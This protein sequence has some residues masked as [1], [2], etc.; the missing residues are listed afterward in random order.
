MTAEDK[1]RMIFR[2]ANT[3]MTNVQMTLW[4]WIL[5]MMVFMLNSNVKFLRPLQN[6]KNISLNRV[7]LA[8]IFR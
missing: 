5:G 1:I 4:F 7:L 3:L 2:P 6:R 8:K